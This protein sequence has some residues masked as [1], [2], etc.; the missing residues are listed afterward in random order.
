MPFKLVLTFTD[1]LVTCLTYHQMKSTLEEKK[2]KSDFLKINISYLQ[3]NN[4][5]NNN[6]PLPLNTPSPITQ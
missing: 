4:N 1:K 3:N 5:N 2:K 6:N